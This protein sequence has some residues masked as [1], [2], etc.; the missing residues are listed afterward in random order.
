MVVA[1]WLCTLC[2]ALWTDEW[3]LAL[4]WA[5]AGDATRAATGRTKASVAIRR[6]NEVITSTCSGRIEGRMGSQSGRAK[7]PN[8][9]TIF[10]KLAVVKSKLF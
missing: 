2:E 10:C 5:M 1:F 9:L 4:L 7:C 8:R 3:C 6:L